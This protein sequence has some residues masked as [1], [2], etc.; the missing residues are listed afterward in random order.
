MDDVKLAVRMLPPKLTEAEF[1]KSI[2]DYTDDIDWSAWEPGYVPEEKGRP[3]T[4]SVCYLHFMSA[5]S[6]AEFSEK[7]DG[8]P[9][10]D[11]TGGMCRCLVELAVNQRIP[12]ERAKKDAREGTIEKDADY[13][14]FV[15]SLGA[16]RPP[17]VSAE[18]LLEM[19]EREAK[20][21]GNKDGIVITPLMAYLQKK[22]GTCGLRPLSV[23]CFYSLF[24]SLAPILSLT[25]I[26][27]S[28]VC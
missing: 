7:L 25:R 3:I 19:Q 2:E 4:F 20:K 28:L 26:L 15:E 9:Y 10:R 21:A 12:E 5:E 6:A 22:Q 14:K 13:L 18:A 24:L 1:F 8:S 17:P 16:E 27:F 11:S 23:L